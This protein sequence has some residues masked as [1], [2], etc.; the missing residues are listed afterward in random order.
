MCMHHC[1]LC[2]CVRY[3]GRHLRRPG[4]SVRTPGTGIP[5]VSLLM[6]V[7]RTEPRVSAKK[8]NKTGASATKK[9]IFSRPCHLPLCVPRSQHGSICCKSE[10]SQRNFT[11]KKKVWIDRVTRKT[12]WFPRASHCS[13]LPRWT[14]TEK[15]GAWLLGWRGRRAAPFHFPVC[16][17]WPE[18]CVPEN[19]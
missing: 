1:L 13:E 19:L 16:H 17:R 2:E 3:V 15:D 7:L 8:Q 5:T 12:C 4:E 6:R 14:V 10:R 18:L 9:L 11:G